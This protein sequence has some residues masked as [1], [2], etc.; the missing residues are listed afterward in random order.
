MTEIKH[1]NG[2]S[3]FITNPVPYTDA[4]GVGTQQTCL[5]S[6]RIL[7]SEV[8]IL[9]TLQILYLILTQIE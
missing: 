4:K 3:L 2:S 9:P 5:N 6:R 8:L 1:T 7:I